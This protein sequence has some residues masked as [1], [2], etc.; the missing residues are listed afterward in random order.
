MNDVL[1]KKER[2]T[3][4]F[5][6]YEKLLTEK[7]REYF[8]SYYFDDLSLAEIASIKEVSRNAV[9][10]GLKKICELLDYYEENLKLAFKFEKINNLIKKYQNSENKEVKEIIEEIKNIE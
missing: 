8:I 1:E 7:Q 3:I 5:D 6:F 4:L 9:F 10:D 2:Y